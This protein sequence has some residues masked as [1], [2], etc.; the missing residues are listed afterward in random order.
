[1]FFFFFLKYGDLLNSE[2]YQLVCNNRLLFSKEEVIDRF[3]KIPLFDYFTKDELLELIRLI[4]NP[5][6]NESEYM[7]FL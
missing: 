2:N 6:L 5:I 7:T 3:R 1:M 4:K